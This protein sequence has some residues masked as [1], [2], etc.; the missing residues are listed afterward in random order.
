MCLMWT[1]TQQE[2]YPRLSVHQWL[3]LV[4]GTDQTVLCPV[5]TN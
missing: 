5:K 3:S 4:L 2:C 1:V